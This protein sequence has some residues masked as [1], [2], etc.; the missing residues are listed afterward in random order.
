MKLFIERWKGM[1][2]SAPEIKK[3]MAEHNEMVL[4]TRLEF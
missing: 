4:A 2:D 1:L 3:L